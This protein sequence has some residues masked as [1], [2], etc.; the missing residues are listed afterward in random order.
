MKTVINIISD[1][2]K[3][4]AVKE[5]ALHYVRNEYPRDAKRIGNDPEAAFQFL[6]AQNIRFGDY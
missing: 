6:K 1:F 5:V 4:R 3:Q 2:F